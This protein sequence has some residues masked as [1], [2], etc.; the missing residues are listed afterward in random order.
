M[1]TVH[2]L[3]ELLVPPEAVLLLCFVHVGPHWQSCGWS[4]CV[5]LASTWL[6]GQQLPLSQVLETQSW[7]AALQQGTLVPVP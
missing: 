2:I 7:I 3:Q 4:R 5:W 1:C 6:A